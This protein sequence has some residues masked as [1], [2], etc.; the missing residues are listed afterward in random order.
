MNADFLD[1][2]IVSDEIDHNYLVF[3]AL[4]GKNFFRGHVVSQD[5]LPYRS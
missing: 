4:I 5:H 3:Y 2:I 1:K